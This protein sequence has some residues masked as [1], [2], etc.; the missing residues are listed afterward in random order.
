ML[1]ERSHEREISRVEPLAIWLE[2]WKAPTSAVTRAGDTIYVSGFPPFDPATG[3]ILNASIERQTELVLEQMKLCLETVIFEVQPRP[4]QW[5]AYLG[6]AKM[7]R[8]EL[9]QV[10]GFVDNVRYRSLTRGGWI[11]SLSAGVM[12]NPLCA[13][14]PGCGITRCRRRAAATSCRTIT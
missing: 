2:N 13:G 8:P 1:P 9:E 14:L 11:L 10:D 4:E 5:D 3:E 7:L 6:S 12:R